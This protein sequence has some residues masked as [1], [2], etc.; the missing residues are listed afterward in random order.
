MGGR[1]VQGLRSWIRRVAGLPGRREFFTEGSV[2]TFISVVGNGFCLR[3]VRTDP[4]PRGVE[5]R[6]STLI[7]IQRSDVVCLMQGCLGDLHERYRVGTLRGCGAFD[8]LR[9]DIFWIICCWRDGAGNGFCLA[10]TKGGA[11]RFFVRHQNHSG[12]V[13]SAAAAFIAVG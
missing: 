9:K 6:D 11:G 7:M 10:G 13:P 1:C 2:Y 8:C 5:C 3:S 4:L 12:G